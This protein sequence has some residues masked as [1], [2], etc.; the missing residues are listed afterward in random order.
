MQLTQTTPERD[1][2]REIAALEQKLASLL[3]HTRA[4]RVAN[5]VLRR[6]LGAA[7]ARN[8]ALAA[9]LTTARERLDVLLAR[10]PAAIE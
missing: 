8:K 3:A 9:R 10:I 1:L 7:N 4:L 2:E 5:D 6:D